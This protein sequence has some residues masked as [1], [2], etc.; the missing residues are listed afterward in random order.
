MIILV[1]AL[2]GICEGSTVTQCIAVLSRAS[3]DSPPYI[4]C[5][6][7]SGDEGWPQ[8]HWLGGSEG[9]R[10]TVVGPGVGHFKRKGYHGDTIVIIGPTIVITDTVFFVTKYHF[11]R[12]I[13]EMMKVIMVTTLSSLAGIEIAIMAVN[14]LMLTTLLSLAAQH[15]RYWLHQRL[16]WWQPLVQA[17][18]KMLP[19]W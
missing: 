4:V 11:C 6:G 15:F 19:A 18:T 13:H 10:E 9:H 8:A 16:P 14:I 12:Y 5:E 3:P 7:H 17:V 2:S 1:S